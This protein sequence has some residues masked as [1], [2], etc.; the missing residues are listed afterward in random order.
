MTTKR[1]KGTRLKEMQ[2]RKDRMLHENGERMKVCGD[3]PIERIWKNRADRLEANRRG[4]LDGDEDGQL[5]ER[6]SE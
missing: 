5:T 6:E 2:T 4:T 1:S 3:V